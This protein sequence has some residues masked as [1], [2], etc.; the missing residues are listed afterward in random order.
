M[1]KRVLSGLFALALL[2][3]AGLGVNK[4][5]KSHAGLS[6]LALANVEALVLPIRYGGI[7]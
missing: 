2:T 7:L 1:E 5:L 3:T 6:D 4:S